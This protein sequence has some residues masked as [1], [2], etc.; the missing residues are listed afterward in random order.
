MISIQIRESD[1]K[2]MNALVEKKVAGIKEISNTMSLQEISKAAFTITGKKFIRAVNTEAKFNESLKHM[3]EWNRAGINTDR[4][5]TVT[6]DRIAGGNLIVGTKFLKSRKPVPIKKELRKSGKSGK[7]VT[8]KNIFKEKARVMEEGRPIR[9]VSKKYLVF[10]GREGNLVFLS[11]GKSVR[12][13]NPGGKAA[14]NGYTKYFQMWYRKNSSVAMS[15]SKIFDQIERSVSKA[16]N[17]QSGGVKEAR[18]AVR[19]ICAKYS[20]GR[21]AL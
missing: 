2:K 13:K 9:I 12:I 21:V 10:P 18:E 8:A 7:S 19:I 1:L 17:N 15:N 3:Y 11:K 14:K 4:L 6:R 5:F 20:E 16:L